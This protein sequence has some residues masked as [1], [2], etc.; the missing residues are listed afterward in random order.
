LVPHTSCRRPGSD[1]RAVERARARRA[2][3][4][5][6]AR[7]EKR[8]GQEVVVALAVNAFP[9]SVAMKRPISHRSLEVASRTAVKR[10]I[11][12]AI[13]TGMNV[14]VVEDQRQ[15]DVVGRAVELAN[16]E[17]GI[18][19]NGR[20]ACRGSPSPTRGRDE[21]QGRETARQESTILM[22]LVLNPFSPRN[23]IFSSP[24]R[25]AGPCP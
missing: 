6:G 23:L 18:G 21:T 15:E 9:P 8:R 4:G 19:V 5:T 24:R 20:P 12:H 3:G 2:G 10:H 1:F 25:F 17:G 13:P 16:M 7:T 11:H 14:L 22:W